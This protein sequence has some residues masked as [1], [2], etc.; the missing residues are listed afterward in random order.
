MSFQE[1][2]KMAKN[3][4]DSKNNKERKPY[5]TPFM[6][7]MENAEEFGWKTIDA[8][9]IAELR[10]KKENNRKP[11]NSDEEPDGEPFIRIMS[12]EE[13]ARQRRTEQDAIDEELL[14]LD[15]ESVCALQTLYLMA[16][17]P[18]KK[19]R[20]RT[21]MMAAHEKDDLV[22]DDFMSA[23]QKQ[24]RRADTLR[25]FAEEDIQNAARAADMSFIGFVG[26][27]VE[28]GLADD[29]LLRETLAH[30][31]GIC[32]AKHSVPCALW[33]YVHDDEHI[34][35]WDAEKT[36]SH[37]MGRVWNKDCIIC[38]SPEFLESSVLVSHAFEVLARHYPLIYDERAGDGYDYEVIANPPFGCRTKMDGS[39]SIPALDEL[40]LSE[41]T[42]GIS[43]ITD[44]VDYD[45]SMYLPECEITD[46]MRS[47]QE[48]GHG[49][50]TKWKVAAARHAD[51]RKDPKSITNRMFSDYLFEY[52]I[53]RSLM[54]DCERK[55][56]ESAMAR[57]SKNPYF[58]GFLSSRIGGSVFASQEMRDAAETMT[59]AIII[60]E[61]RP[62]KHPS[63]RRVYTE[64]FELLDTDRDCPVSDEQVFE[65]FAEQMRDLDA[66]MLMEQVRSGQDVWDVLKDPAN[67]PYLQNTEADT[68]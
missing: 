46:K 33:L 35:N 44:T 50:Y 65:L 57:R 5:K 41:C 21:S 7:L 53:A 6:G 20:Y 55:A 52:G 62:W 14:Q 13:T 30:L 32:V 16:F 56:F 27:E 43:F 58:V 66:P 49:S 60:W 38:F 28:S 29:R 36:V 47:E 25:R 68:E 61:H 23:E 19:L 18:Q 40:L 24:N 45:W 4:P 10:K 37:A 34:A 64:L 9:V 2:R 1:G 54:S 22:D 3:E 48:E 26:W 12:K 17:E 8:D 11:E 42:A 59:A 15:V 67:R 31:R 39:V 51:D 63:G